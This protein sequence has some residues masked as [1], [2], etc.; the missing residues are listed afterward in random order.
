MPFQNELE[1]ATVQLAKLCHVLETNNLSIN[2]KALGTI[3]P[4][5]YFQFFIPMY[6]NQ[7]SQKLNEKDSEA[8]INSIVRCA[9]RSHQKIAIDYPTPQYIHDLTESEV[10]SLFSC[11]NQPEKQNQITPIDPKV[12]KPLHDLQPLITILPPPTPH[13]M[14]DSAKTQEDRLPLKPNANETNT[15]EKLREIVHQLIENITQGINRNTKVEKH[16]KIEMLS[17]IENELKK[18]I[19]EIL[20]D[21]MQNEFIQRIMTAC[22]KKRN[23]IHFW[24]T[25][26]SVN[27]F[28]K[29][30][31]DKGIN[32]PD[33][34]SAPNKNL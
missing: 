14:P 30:L 32:Y 21:N 7:P 2:Y 11:I 25:P 23:P 26:H 8:F 20:S 6:K 29:L 4:A 33:K 13:L 12:P 1:K 28:K 19:D 9:L 15:T 16:P 34:S 17:G 3:L 31:D 5:L 10:T 24:A 18:R 22:E 27:E